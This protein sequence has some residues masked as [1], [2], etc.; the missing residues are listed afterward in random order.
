MV[1]TESVLP[2]SQTCNFSRQRCTHG[3]ILAWHVQHATLR[4]S[5][6]AVTW[7]PLQTVRVS[8]QFRLGTHS[9]CCG[10]MLALNDVSLG[11]LPTHCCFTERHSP[12]SHQ[13]KRLTLRSFVPLPIKHVFCAFV[14]W[15]FLCCKIN[16]C[17]KS[18]TV[19]MTRHSGSTRCQ[20]TCCAHPAS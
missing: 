19:S 16:D 18:M 2:Q 20:N 17:S 5:E 9:A 6:P 8:V 10:V 12:K 11:S 14:F 3:E 7:S 13:V 15:K 1:H 4:N